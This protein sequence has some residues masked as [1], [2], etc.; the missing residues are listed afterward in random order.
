MLPKLLFGVI[1][2][3]S[4]VAAQ[5]I[6][7]EHAH[8]LS[9]DGSEFLSGYSVVVAGGKIESVAREP[10]LP[11]DAKRIDLSGTWLIPGLMD[12]HSHLL[13]HPYDE[14]AWNDQ[15]LQESHELRTI[16][17]TVAARKTLAAG[18]T[19]LRD[20]GTEGAGY[21]DVALRDAIA[22]GL[23]PGPRIFAATR[24]IVATA[25]YGPQGLAPH[26]SVPKG[27]QEATGVDGVRKVVREQIAGGAD[28][29][30]VYAD[31]PRR[32]GDTAT[33]T[34]SLPELVAICDEAKSA[35]LPVSAHATTSE[36]IRRAVLAG[37]RTIEHGYQASSEVLQLMHD[38][39]VALCPTL[40][41]AESYA[42]YAGWK[43]GQPEPARIRQSR[44]MFRRAL[45][46]NVTIACGSDVGVF[47]HGDNARELELMVEYGMTTEQ[48]LRA[49]TSVAA[50]VLDKQNELGRIHA[51]Y[52]ADLVAVRENPLESISAL[53]NP[54]FVMKAGRVYQPVR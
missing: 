40:T 18:F 36:G 33:P 24:A 30:K 38:K 27:A 10:K 50:A 5:T 28:W 41:A 23:I 1:A 32:E 43:L 21:A 46:A 26:V 17:A 19:T 51:G 52:T 15:V 42:R 11:D 35:G 45:D 54:A 48:A 53:R 12:L 29:I 4:P 6:V 39:G 22:S 13:L 2:L 37:V 31:Y 14:A 8:V 9:D 3:L 44:A 49:A 7:L 47:A 16:R 25:C 34:F 20:L